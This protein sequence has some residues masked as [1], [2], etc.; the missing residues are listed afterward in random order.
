MIE[1]DS[2][3]PYV[4]TSVLQRLRADPSSALRSDVENVQ[5]AALFVDVADSTATVESLAERG[6]EGVERFSALLGSYFAGLICA[7]ERFGGEV[8][9]FDG[10]AVLAIWS[11]S[12]ASVLADAVRQAGACAFA[13]QDAA[14]A[15]TNGGEGRLVL[16]AGVGAG[17]ACVVHVSDGAQR[18]EMFLVGAAWADVMEASKVAER[19]AVAF[20]AEARAFLELDGAAVDPAAER[21]AVRVAV[22]EAG[23]LFPPPILADPSGS[24]SA[25]GIDDPVAS[26]LVHYVPRAVRTRSQARGSPWLA[27]LRTV[28][29]VFVGLGLDGV[30]VDSRLLDAVARVIRRI[31][32]AGGNVARVGAQ[33]N[34]VAVLAAFGLPPD[35][36]EDDADRALRTAMVLHEELLATGIET[37]VGVTTGRVFC[38][39]VGSGVRCEYTMIGDSV[40]VAARLM[41]AARASLLCDSSTRQASKGRV[42]FGPPREIAARGRKGAVRVFEP[43]GYA[44]PRPVAAVSLVGRDEQCAQFD[45]ALSDLELRGCGAVFVVEGEAGI[46]KSHLAMFTAQNAAAHGLDVAWARAESTESQVPF[47]AWRTV[48]AALMGFSTGESA[49]DKAVDADFFSEPVE[50]G[51]V[52]ARLVRQ[53]GLE[54]HQAHRVAPLLG[55]VLGVTFEDNGWTAKLSPQARVEQTAALVLRVLSGRTEPSAARVEPLA[56]PLRAARLVVVL[57][58]A[59]WFDAA[60]WTLLRTAAQASSSL[61]LVVTSRPVQSADYRSL[62]SG[63]EVRC[64]VLSGL[65]SEGVAALAARRLNV[66]EVPYPLIQLLYERSQGHP[67]FVIELVDLLRREGA[68]ALHGGECRLLMSPVNL[69]RLGLPATVESLIGGRIAQ[70]DEGATSVLKLAAVVGG[71]FLADDLAAV[72]PERRE[73]SQIEDALARLVDAGLLVPVADGA[74]SFSFRNSITQTVAYEMLTFSLRRSL[75]RAVAESLGGGRAKVPP[76]V[77]AYHWGRAIDRQAPQIEIVEKAT[78]ANEAA[79]EQAIGSFDNVAAAALFSEAL[80]M[81]RLQPDVAGARR[82]AHWY[83]RIGEASYRAGWPNAAKS[84]LMAALDLLGAPIPA[85]RV[86]VRFSIA[87]AAARQVAHLLRSASAGPPAALGPA[88]EAALREQASASALLSFV[89]VL[90]HETEA[91]ILAN[92][93]ALNAA[94]G[95]GPSSE[96]AI[97]AAAFSQL[98][99]LVLGERVERHYF[100]IA[101]RSAEICGDAS[102]RG[103]VWWMRSIYLL[104][105]A[106]WAAA[107]EVL[108]KSIGFFQE[109]GDGRAQETSVMAMGNALVLASRLDDALELYE[110]GYRAAHVRGDVQDEAWSH[111]GMSNSTLMLGRHREALAS[112][113]KVESWVGGDLESLGDHASRLAVLG[114]R[115]AILVYEGDGIGARRVLEQAHALLGPSIYLYH[116]VTGYT[117]VTEAALR[118]LEAARESRRRRGRQAIEAVVHERFVVE[119]DAALQRMADDFERRLWIF[120]RVMPIGRAQALVWRG[121]SLWLRGK[122]SR[123]LRAWNRAAVVAASLAMP[124]E[125]ALARYEAGRH[126]PPEDPRR[127]TWLEEARDLFA[128]VGAKYRLRCV[129]DEIAASRR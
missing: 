54:L 52:E 48:V 75:H 7:V 19:G 58:N 10:D 38:G 82:M 70:L 4:S 111:V 5:V 93:R 77:L 31:V 99:G 89:L 123:A 108:E 66:A 59:H 43:I 129:E 80:A 79:G 87:G 39:P 115:A 28:T 29:T 18:S 109:C 16:R 69:D 92:L 40:N 84:N 86:K 127:L 68:L 56:E 101:R 32:H 2:L 50:L 102:T 76:A 53:C 37:S 46:G 116:A 125:R 9:K 15:L 85:S 128:G 106:R 78:A 120:G 118:L 113:A 13:F 124:H 121:S 67:F 74:G 94:D 51:A 112:L 20:G 27:E 65:A 110:S 42:R 122:R 26:A 103:R 47:H 107:Y 83:R 11:C 91:S 1:L 24:G 119:E 95:L 81:A 71:A 117:F 36:H 35:A 105:R 12:D 61:L 62:L 100:D 8:F 41:N 63:P 25:S 88:V 114:M 45:E 57:E 72:D 3:V 21:A 96:L 33:R 60:S 97:C 104:G 64:I 17:P 90:M 6:R 126:L 49:G 98:G 73:R 55:A 30:E 23:D 44:Q 14:S 22:G 34:G